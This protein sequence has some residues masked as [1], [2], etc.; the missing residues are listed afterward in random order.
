MQEK[1]N[2]QFGDQHFK[3]SISLIELYK[4]RHGHYPPVLDS[5]EYTGDWDQMA[6]SS[7]D[8]KLLNEGYELNLVTGWIGKPDSLA[9]PS[10]FWNGLGYQKIKSDGSRIRCQY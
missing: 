10:G 1:A 8:Y 9:Y 5:L 2:V 6:I 3:T 7:V 4:V